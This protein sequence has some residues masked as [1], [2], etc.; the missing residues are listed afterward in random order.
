MQ[1]WSREATIESCSKLF[2]SQNFHFKATRFRRT[3]DCVAQLSDLQECEESRLIQISIDSTLVGN[4]V[5]TQSL[6]KF[7]GKNRVPL[8]SLFIFIR[9]NQV[10]V[11]LQNAISWPMHIP[12]SWALEMFFQVINSPVTKMSCKSQTSPKHQDSHFVCRS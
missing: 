12:K 4:F 6:S 10:K 8:T 9:K 3:C 11:L 7:S 1:E 2:Y 5:F